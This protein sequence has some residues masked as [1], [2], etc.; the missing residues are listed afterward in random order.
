MLSSEFLALA[1][2]YPLDYSEHTLSARTCSFCLLEQQQLQSYCPVI[3]F[4]GYEGLAA[5]AVVCV[6]GVRAPSG[7]LGAEHLLD[8]APR[9]FL[10]Y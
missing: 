7:F 4:G 6:E 8:A 5:A 3:A 1:L 9:H 2:P 10:G